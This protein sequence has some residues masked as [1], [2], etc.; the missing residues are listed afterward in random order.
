MTL[1]PFHRL[2][3]LTACFLG[4][5]LTVN[6]TA[7]ESSSP[8][9]VARMPREHI[10]VFKK[11]CFDCHSSESEE[12]GVNLQT[13]PFEISRDIPTADLW[14][15]ILNAINSGE[16]PPPDSEPLSNKD[17]AAFL[18]ALSSQMVVAR[19]ILSDSGGVIT[20]RRLN[21][22][23]YQN[24]VE[25]LTGIRPNVVTLPDD[26]ANSGFDTA[27]ASLFFSSDQLEQ[28]L[29]VA[30]D[31]LKLAFT[32]R[33]ASTQRVTRIEAE[34]KYTP[35][36]RDLLSQKQEIQKQAET[37]LAQS[38]RPATDFGFLDQGQAEKQLRGVKQTIPILVDYLI[39]PESESG[40]PLLMMIKPGMTRIGTRILRGGSGREVLLRVRV[41]AYSGVS[42]RFHYLECSMRSWSNDY[43]KQIGW[44]KISGTV[45][46]PQIVEFPVALPD[47]EDVQFYVHQ[48]T[49]QG[50]GDKNLISESRRKQGLGTPP[51][52]WVDWLEVVTPASDAGL[53]PTAQKILFPK[54]DGWNEEDY[55]RDVVRRFASTA[56]RTEQPSED[57]IDKLVT[58][59]SIRR[60]EGQTLIDALIEPLSI[61][62][63]SPS[64]LYMVESSGGTESL[65]DLELAVRL[66]YFL[67]SAPPDE[68][69]L[70]IAKAGQLSDASVLKQQTHRLLHDRRAD[71]F[72]RGFA[73]QWLG[74]ERLGMFQFEARLYPEFDNGVRESAREEVY[75]TIHTMLREKLPLKTLL[76]SN[77]VVIND[78]LADF[79]GIEDV[80]G[81]HFRKVAVESG[82]PRGGLLGSAAVLAMGSDGIRTSP[83]ERG[84][85]VLR[86]LLHDPPPPA[87]PNV[88]QISRLEGEVFS[89]RKL[90]QA[91]QQDP[92]CAQCH[93]RIDPI[94]YGLENFNAVGRWRDVET[95]RHGKRFSQSDE[96][97]IEPAG[98]LRDGSQF[99]DYFGLRDVVARRSEA[100]ARG[101]TEALIEYGLGRPYGFTDQE[102]ADDILEYALQDDLELSLFI[103]GL[104]QSKQFQSK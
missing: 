89:A 59:F 52:L 61:V 20:L 11:Y 91:H 71:R 5:L 38:G 55:A 16:M 73:Y 30:R 66:S 68:E 104:V 94:G 97:P 82:S 29:A 65:T 53:S 25:A 74:L 96:F 24:T 80:E 6:V 95:V 4:L 42:P 88:P 84:A 23:E 27:G 64:F 45:D 44:R 81:H 87:P 78:L 99:S 33:S 31:T 79:Y 41:G 14:A 9:P 76:K 93:R 86:H 40:A 2:G 3:S 19:R 63:T 72:V 51:G 28:Y 22:R 58:R 34:E 47:G 36:Y 101:L 15:K 90:Q 98:Q 13:I 83:V 10:A 7:A 92:Q 39:R 32:S 69:L 57:Y 77:F 67:W 56:F 85:W 37:F 1:K 46:A 100:F 43:T 75:Q 21:R 49:H 26:Q 50:R 17:K 48:R 12:G 70:H 102:L 62:L 8:Q 60:S 54:P 35:L 18:E 103:H